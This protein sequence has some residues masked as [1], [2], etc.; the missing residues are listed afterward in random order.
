MKPGY[1]SEFEII[2]DQAV[3]IVVNLIVSL[4]K[5]RIISPRFDVQLG[6]VE[7]WQKNLLPSRQFGFLVQTTSAG[8]TNHEEARQT[9]RRENPGFLFLGM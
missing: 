1:V 3:K 6:D 5:F 2:D 7:K 8:I 4:D 9:H